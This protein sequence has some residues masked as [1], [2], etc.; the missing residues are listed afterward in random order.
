MLKK[1]IFLLCLLSILPVFANTE[2]DSLRP[3]N[4]QFLYFYTSDCGYCV[5]FNPIY[6]R[7][8]NKFKKNCDFIKIDASTD[9]GNLM[10]REY[11]AYY[12]PYVILVDNHSKTMN[13]LSPNCLLNYSCS[14]DAVEK[15]IIK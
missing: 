5:R 9:S 6:N 15:L 13:R 3:N 11:N 4:K 7:L 2:R 10:M 14:K 1:V 12:V 8:K